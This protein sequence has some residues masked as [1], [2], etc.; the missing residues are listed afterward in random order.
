MGRDC[1]GELA[2]ILRFI[3]KQDADGSGNDTDN[4]CEACEEL[5]RIRFICKHIIMQDIK[6]SQ[7]Y[8]ESDMTEIERMRKEFHVKMD[9]VSLDVQVGFNPKPVKIA[10]PPVIRTQIWDILNGI[11]LDDSKTIGDAIG[12]HTKT[13]PYIKGMR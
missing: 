6:A 4:I 12:S 7:R 8:S 13:N 9:S 1:K 5:E 11:K 2:T 3:E 10:L